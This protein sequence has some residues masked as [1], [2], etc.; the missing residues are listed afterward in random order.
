[1]DLSVQLQTLLGAPPE[2][3]GEPAE[4]EAAGGAAAAADDEESPLLLL[5]LLQALLSVNDALD[6]DD[7]YRGLDD[8]VLVLLLEAVDAPFVWAGMRVT[9]SP[10]QLGH[11]DCPSLFPALLFLWAASCSA[12]IRKRS[13]AKKKPDD[14][15]GRRTGK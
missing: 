8:D 2:I 4:P 13:S 15:M 14:A 5:L 9:I 6:D 1:M 3:E 10:S 11:T 7:T 12:N